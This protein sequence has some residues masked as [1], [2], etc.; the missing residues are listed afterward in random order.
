MLQ[1][2]HW[3]V[4][5]TLHSWLSVLAANVRLVI[6]SQ[7]PISRFRGLQHAYPWYVLT[8]IKSIKILLSLSHCCQLSETEGITRS[9]FNYVSCFL[10]DGDKPPLIGGFCLLDW[11]VSK[12]VWP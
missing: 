7:S 4:Q 11:S 6:V 2:H 1:I 5:A 12:V 9:Y 10:V 8:S 3:C